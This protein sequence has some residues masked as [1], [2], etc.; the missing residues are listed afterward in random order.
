MFRRLLLIAKLSEDGTAIIISFENGEI[1]L[2]HEGK[3]NN[4][5]VVGSEVM[6]SE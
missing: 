2:N 3:G 4:T 5:T 6:I 1:T